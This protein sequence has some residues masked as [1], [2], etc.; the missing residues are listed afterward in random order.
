MN[1]EAG[2]TVILPTLNEEK[3][4][5][6]LVAEISRLCPSAIVIVADDG[7]R[8]STLEIAKKAG[9]TVLDRKNEG[10]KGIT[11]SVLDALEKVETLYFVVIDSDFQHPPEKICEIV[12]EL[13]KGNDL[14]CARRESVPN[15]GLHRRIISLGA[16]FL[17][18]TRLT[19]LGNPVPRDIMSGFFG[20]RTEFVKAS[21]QK[22]PKRFVGKGYKVL[23]DLVK[24]MKKG[25]VKIAEVPYVFGMRQRGTSKISMKHILFY[26]E[27]VFR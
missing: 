1:K 2:F 24:G 13:E 8:D 19:L 10:V 3:N 25:E 17:G 9:A 4:I 15:W 22:N 16:D 23:F 27:S 14:V 11:A 21:V 18:K 12:S 5:G 6:E 26:L 7:S 20:G